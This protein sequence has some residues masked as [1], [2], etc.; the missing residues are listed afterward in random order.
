MPCPVLHRIALPVVS[1]DINFRSLALAFRARRGLESHPR[2][3]AA[4]SCGSSAL[5]RQVYHTQGR[6][7]RSAPL[8]ISAVLL[9]LDR[10]PDLHQL[11][12]QFRF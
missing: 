2:K 10:T 12:Y 9:A 3:D 8:L 11:R 7:L 1:D 4:S 5:S 6:S